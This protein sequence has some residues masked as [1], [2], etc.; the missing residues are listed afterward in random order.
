MIWKAE[1]V[2]QDVARVPNGQLEDQQQI[3]RWILLPVV[4]LHSAQGKALFHRTWPWKEFRY[5]RSPQ[6]KSRQPKKP[7][8]DPLFVSM[9]LKLFST[10]RQNDLHEL[11]CG[12]DTHMCDQ[13]API[14]MCES[15][16][17]FVFATID[18]QLKKRQDFE[19][20]P[21]LWVTAAP[22]PCKSRGT[23]RLW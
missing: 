22:S 19:P 8:F 12:V 17:S 10:T 23:A 3:D 5:S 4:M 2:H 16:V 9:R 11:K 15:L 13:M 20:E 18:F 1:T 14:K 6:V 21:I 7:P